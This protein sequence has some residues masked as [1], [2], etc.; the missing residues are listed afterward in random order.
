MFNDVMVKL[1]RA[2]AACLEAL[3]KQASDV[4]LPAEFEERCAVSR[5]FVM[6]G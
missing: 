5:V 3:D 2:K 1:D 6:A 4:V